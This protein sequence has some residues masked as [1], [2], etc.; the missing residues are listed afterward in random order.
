MIIIIA[1]AELNFLRSESVRDDIFKI[2]DIIV[3]K[4]TVAAQC[5]RISCNVGSFRFFPRDK[6]IEKNGR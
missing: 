2:E 4:V 3:P 1:V 5:G 6:V